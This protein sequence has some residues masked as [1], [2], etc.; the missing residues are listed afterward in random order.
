[1]IEWKKLADQSI[2]LVYFDQ[3]LIF[4]LRLMRQFKPDDLWWQHNFYRI[5]SIWSVLLPKRRQRVLLPNRPPEYF[6]SK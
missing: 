5:N 4:R 3:F 2:L 6:S 1:M